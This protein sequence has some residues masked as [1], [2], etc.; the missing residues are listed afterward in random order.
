MGDFTVDSDREVVKPMIQRMVASRQQQAALEG[1][2]D[3]FRMLEAMKGVLL[4]GLGDASD[5]TP[6]ENLEGWM[7]RMEFSQEEVTRARHGWTP[8]RFAAYLGQR[9]FVLELL[10]LGADVNAP[11]ATAR[12]DW[13]LQSRGST[14]LQGLS[15]LKDDPA[16]LE[17][18]MEH[19]ADPRSRQP[20]NGFTALHF[21][22]SS[23]HCGNIRAIM[24]RAPDAA[25]IREGL[26][27]QPWVC[28]CVRGKAE[29]L[30]L[31]LDEYPEKVGSDPQLTVNGWGHSFCCNA[32]IDAGDVRTLQ[33]LLDRQYDVNHVGK[34]TQVKARSIIKVAQAVCHVQRDPGSLMEYVANG[35]SM[36]ALCHAAYHG[37]LGA[38]ELLL[39]SSADVHQTNGYGRTAL[40]FAAMRGHEGV[41][42]LLLRARAKPAALDCWGLSAAAWAERR[43][44]ARLAEALQEEQPAVRRA[45][46]DVS[47][48]RGRRAAAAAAHVRRRVGALC[49]RSPGGAACA[50][51]EPG[52]APS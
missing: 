38:V 47:S 12:I 1:D 26:G 42:E 22:C 49:L 30:R 10:R 52:R 18:L 27:A 20:G 39:R 3:Y 9:D 31:F 7:A 29:A 14:V 4:Q 15:A 5:S 37:N 25:D 35:P 32:V 6:P 28:S 50:P 44:H 11:L 33:V 17:L 2:L 43:G 46:T 51:A 45:H 41:A 24:A 40:T 34:A 23:G 13:G 8:L 48:D 21:A 19:G 36:P 16:M